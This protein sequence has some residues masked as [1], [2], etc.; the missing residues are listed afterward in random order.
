MRP[1]SS[2]LL[3][4]LFQLELIDLLAGDQRGFAAVGDFELLHH[5]AADHFDVLVV[6]L[7]A[8]QTI[9]VLDFLDQIGRQFL[10][11][12]DAQDVV[13]RGIAFDDVIALLHIIAF[14]HADVLALGD[15]IL[16]RFD[17]VATSASR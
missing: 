12:L 10:H 17:L 13:R 6:D 9:D 11:A 16:G 1:S 3:V 8:L 2:G 14:A 4:G 7:H 15:Q 5:L